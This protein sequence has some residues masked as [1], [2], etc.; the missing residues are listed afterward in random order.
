M[1]IGVDVFNG[2][3]GATIIPMV[4]DFIIVGVS[5]GLSSILIGL[6][7]SSYSVIVASTY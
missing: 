7:S 2:A 5:G 6:T 1:D 3:I 4:H